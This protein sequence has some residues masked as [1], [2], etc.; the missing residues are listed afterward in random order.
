MSNKTQ[1]TPNNINKKDA[2]IAL[3]LKYLSKFWRTPE[4]IL[5]NCKI[6]LILTWYKDYVVSAATG[7]KKISNNRW[8]TLCSSSDF[9]NSR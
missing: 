5:V 7:A 9:I 6:N 4:M 2:E 8:W 1:S 3:P